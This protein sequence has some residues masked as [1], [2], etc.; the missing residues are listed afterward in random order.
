ML[1]IE[2]LAQI[3]PKTKRETLEKYV[4]PL[5][6]ALTAIGAKSKK[7]MAAFL[8]QVMHESGELVFVVENLNYGAE[9]LLKVFGKY[10]TQSSAVTYARKPEM[11]ANRVYANRMGNGDERSGDGWKFRGR[12][13]IQIT[14]RNNY[15][16]F[17][18]SFNMTVDQAVDFAMT[19]T[20]AVA[21]A[22]WFWISNKLNRFVDA[23]D[24]VGLTKA[25]NGGTNGI[26][27]RTKLY[28]LAMKVL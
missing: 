26:E 4:T 13:L 11:I 14:G 16:A 18:K 12:G 19:P 21:T 28:E 25:I 5:N 17:A 22:S 10:F 15:T 6:N 9:G 3:A 8:A 23:D 27:H 24:F 2:K 7:H 20:G 1:T